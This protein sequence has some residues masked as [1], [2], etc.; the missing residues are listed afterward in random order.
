MNGKFVLISGSAGQSCLADKL[1]V[2]FQF[3]QSFTGEV[4]RRGGGIVALAGDE[5]STKHERGA[6]R[7]FDWMA[8]REVERYA[9]STTESPRPYA[10]VIMSDEAWEAK[11]DDANLGLLR[12]LEQRD[13]IELH[14]IRREVFTGGEYRKAMVA[15]SRR[16]ARNRRRQ[17][18]AYRWRRR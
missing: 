12:N 9:A 8:L 6:P 18:H 3:V 5:A 17:G 16:H 10:R 4:L 2:A 13:A 7:V 1:D 15:R 11:I 14:H